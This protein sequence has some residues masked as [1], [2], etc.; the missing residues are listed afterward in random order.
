MRQFGRRCGD[1]QAGGQAGGGDGA[2]GVSAAVCILMTTIDSEAAAGRLA[3]A[4]LDA[5]LAACV[6]IF[7]IQSHYIW[8]GEMREDA[9]FMLH[10]KIRASDYAAAQALVLQLHRYDTP[11]ILRIDVAD[12]A[13][14]YLDWVA[15]NT[16][17]EP[18]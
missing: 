18:G 11:E 3:K 9:E 17:R 4:M 10:M 5:R 12:G 14:A 6:Q 7:P 16:R 8:Q 2:T 13:P 15:A 1:G